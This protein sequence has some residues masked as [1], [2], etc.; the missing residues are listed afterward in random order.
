MKGETLK[1]KGISILYVKLQSEIKVNITKFIFDEFLTEIKHS[2][3]KNYSI[4]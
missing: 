2:R 1:N 4:L 3:E